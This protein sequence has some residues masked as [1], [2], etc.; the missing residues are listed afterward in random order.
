M[1]ISTAN[2]GMCLC[3]SC[4]I[5]YEIIYLPPLGLA[6]VPEIVCLDWSQKPFHCQLLDIFQAECSIHDCLT[7]ATFLTFMS[8]I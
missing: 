4:L 5:I 6:L 3:V 7:T 8:Q 1:H 2:K